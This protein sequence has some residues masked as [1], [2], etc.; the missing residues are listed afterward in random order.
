MSLSLSISFHSLPIDKY[1][2]DFFILADSKSYAIMH[3]DVYQGRNAANVNIHEEAKTLPTTQKAV[4][5]AVFQIGL[6]NDVQHGYRKISMDNRYQCPE[7]AVVLRDR[8][9]ILSTGTC[10]KNRKG[11]PKELM[12]MEKAGTERGDSMMAYDKVNDVLAIQWRDNRVVN[13]CTTLLDGTLEDTTRRE[14]Q[15]LRMLKVPRPLKEY[16]RY[17]F[18]VDKGDQRRMHLGGFA[19]KAHFKKW[20]KKSFFAVLDCMLLNSLIAWNTS[21]EDPSLERSHMERYDFYAWI[22]DDLLNYNEPQTKIPPVIVQ[23]SKPIT[24]ATHRK[25]VLEDPENSHARCAVCMLDANSSKEWKGVRTKV[26][27]CSSCGVCV[28]EHTLK[29]KRSIHDLFTEGMTCHEIFRSD[30]GQQI[31]ARNKEQGGKQPKQP[32]SVK[33]NHPKVMELRLKHGRSAKKRNRNVDEDD[34][35]VLV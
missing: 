5:N 9:K 32:Y 17:M 35:I 24:Q 34:T 14:G 11:W 30:E 6:D 12:N 15:L 21:S 8:C 19:R 18:G 4:V 7:L 22:A 23:P 2:V 26:F 28:H 20:Y 27:Y 13:C 1:R 33:T 29:E 16:H 31:W 25:C 3:M 10:R